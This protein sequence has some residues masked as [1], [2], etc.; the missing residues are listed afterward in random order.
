MEKKRILHCIPNMAG[1]GAERQLVYLSEELVRRG[2]DVHVALI[3]EGSNFESLAATGTAIHKISTRG[4]HDLGLLWRLMK[5]IR[6]IRPR[7]VQTW[8][9][10]MDV[11]GGISSRLTRTPFILSERSCAPAYPR[12]SS[13]GCACLPVDMPRRSYPTRLAAAGIGR[14]K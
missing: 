7:L 6:A 13:T 2:W 14:C 5:L 10:Q 1:G 9:T 8:L 4:N 12:V 11:C 3:K